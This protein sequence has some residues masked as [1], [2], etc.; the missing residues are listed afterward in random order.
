[1]TQKIKPVRRQKTVFYYLERGSGEGSLGPHPFH[2]FYT[3]MFIEDTSLGVMPIGGRSR[4]PDF[5][6]TLDP[7]NPTAEQMVAT[8]LSDDA[9]SY[10]DELESAVCDFFR[11]CSAQIAAFDRA[12]YEIVFLEE[13]TKKRLVGFDL[14]FIEESQLIR[15]GGSIYQIVPEQIAKERG[16]PELIALDERDLMVFVAPIRFRKP[17][18]KMRIG[19][20]RIEDKRMTTLVME[21]SQA[22]LPYDFQE[23]QR[24]MKLALADI[25]RPIGWPARGTFND[26]VLSYYWIQMSIL[27][28]EFKIELREE[29]LK[30][31]N[32]GLRQVGRQLEFEALLKIDG[33]PTLNDA[34]T[35]LQNLESGN[36]PFT[37][38]M[39]V[40][41]QNS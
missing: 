4:R 39:D 41:E 19:L 7:S 32:D 25:V 11:K 28:H 13:P 29:I 6:I 33:L 17:L 24:S 35:A 9:Y 20:S 37:T 3:R 14:V 27:F 5:N 8:A 31:L 36:M 12:T 16:V 10:R 22:G 34:K 38:V 23:H 30:S 1:M 18:Q 40:F 21:A 15:K 26:S 2:D